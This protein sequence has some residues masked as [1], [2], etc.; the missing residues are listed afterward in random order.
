MRKDG[1]REIIEGKPAIFRMDIF[2]EVFWT[3]EPAIT[4]KEYEIP[5]PVHILCMNGHLS[6][7]IDFLNMDSGFF[8]KFSL[9]S[10]KEGFSCFLFSSGKSPI[11]RPMPRFF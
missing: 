10:L 3:S 6:R 11:E 4:E 2:F 5:F 8:E 9:C 1:M 7:H